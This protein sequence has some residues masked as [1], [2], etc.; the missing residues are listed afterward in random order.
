M[1]SFDVVVTVVSAVLVF[2]ELSLAGG[3]SPETALS[4]ADA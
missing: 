1:V 4:Y 3:D 2:D